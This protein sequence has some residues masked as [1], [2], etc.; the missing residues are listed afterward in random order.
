MAMVS[1]AASAACLGLLSHLGIFIHGE[2]HIHSARI[3]GLYIVLF[4]SI[5][6]LETFW[7]AGH[8]KRAQ[9][10]AATI[11]ASYAFTLMTSITLYRIFFHPL[12]DF[13]GPLM[14]RVTKLWNVAHAARSTNFR[15]MEDMR[16]SYG[17]FVRTGPNEVSVFLPEAVRAI[18]GVGT[19]C[20]K[21]AWYDIMQPRVSLATTRD[22]GLHQGRRRQWE[23][24]F[25]PAALKDYE[26]RLKNFALH[27]ERAVD[28]SNGRRLDVSRLFYLYSLDVMSD[29]AFGEPLYMLTSNR[30]HFVVGLLQDGMDLLGPL[31]PVPWLVRIG[32][33]IPGVASKF[34][35][36][37]R[38]SARKLEHRMQHE[39]TQP[40]VMSWLLEASRENGSLVQDQHWLRGDAFA[41]IVAGSDTVASTLISIFFHL[42]EDP[43][44]IEKLGSELEDIDSPF[45]THALAAKP[46]LNGVINEALRLHPA[47]PSG[48]LRQTPA[49]GLIVAGR[50]LPGDTVISAPR[51]SLGRQS[52]YE[53]P[54]DFIPERWYSKPTMVRNK[55]GFAPFST[56]RYNCIGKPLALMQIRSVVALLITGFDVHFA[57]DGDRLSVWKDLKDQFNSH[58]GKLHLVFRKRPSRG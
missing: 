6:V 11:T 42:A 2:H 48:G 23:R 13:P 50:Y 38:W 36:L 55:A 15:L 3:F 4:L 1:Q 58:P 22:I 19:K 46:H 28:Q 54:N 45:A 20:S 35:A 18:D 34:K 57:P 7:F 31:S 43:T 29:L 10:A 40:D 14:A 33:S 39:P 56:G 32:L 17:D 24:A 44:Q 41:L 52:C 16:R 5:L 21:S 9:L 25:S 12:R 49:E 51:Y 53:R 8:F 26:H 37:L 27:L 30:N 47:L